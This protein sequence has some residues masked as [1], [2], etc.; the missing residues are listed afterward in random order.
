M[1]CPICLG[2]LAFWRAL[3]VEIRCGTLRC[4]RCTALLRRRRLFRRGRANA[5]MLYSVAFAALPL[6]L[7]RALP[8]AW[9]APLAIV[10]WPIG[11][12]WLGA[13]YV[14]L[15]PARDD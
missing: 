12:L 9:A 11:L 3:F 15:E 2:R 10:L 1:R 6:A 5:R 4:P 14:E 8:P 7:G 13:R